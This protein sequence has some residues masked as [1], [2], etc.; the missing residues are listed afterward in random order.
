MSCYA[1]CIRVSMIA[2]TNVAP[3]KYE[4]RFVV[5]VVTCIYEIKQKGIHCNDY[6]TDENLYM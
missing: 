4:V 2:Y 5:G 1:I 3:N 6:L